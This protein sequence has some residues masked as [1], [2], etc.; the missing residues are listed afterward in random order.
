MPQDMRGQPAAPA[1]QVPCGGLG[2][3]GADA[4][5]GAPRYFTGGRCEDCHFA[6]ERPASCLACFAF[7]IHGSGRVCAAC[8]AFARGKT[9]GPC[10][11]CSR[12]V[13]LKAGHCRLCWKQAAFARSAGRHQDIRRFLDQPILCHQLFFAGMASSSRPA[14]PGPSALHGTWAP[15]FPQA[16][17]A[18]AVPL[19][20][21]EPPPRDFSRF[22]R[23]NADLANPW[24]A[25]ARYQACLHGEAHGWT[26][27]MR[28]CA[29]R[30]L[31]AVLSRHASGERIRRSDLA[32]AERASKIFGP[33][34][35]DILDL[36]GLLDDDRLPALDT[37]ITTTTRGL[38]PGI[39]DDVHYWLTVLRDGT[40]RHRP[41]SPLTVCNH[42]RDAL[43]AL[44]A[45][46]GRYQHLRQVTRSDVTAIADAL[47]G[48]AR[49]RTMSA[50]RSLFRI[51]KGAGRIFRNPAS[52]INGGTPAP[53]LL[54]PLGQ[55]AYDR[56]IQAATQPPARL[57]LALAAMHAA[58]PHAI[59]HLFLTDIDIGDGRITL[60][61]HSRPLDPITRAV[62]LEYLGYRRTRWPGTANPHLLV[63]RSTA[64]G[65]NP[66][67]HAWIK[68]HFTGLTATIEQMRTGRQLEEALSAGPDPLH[69]AAVFGISHQTAIRYAH[70]ARRLL[71][72]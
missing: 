62:V 46:S 58:R 38:T 65:R 22:R 43:P 56:A 8:R 61:G 57:M 69:L 32:T 54:I 53:S 16:P 52:G 34:L 70:A 2:Q 1:R 20:L 37:W 17:A 71:T 27:Q 3:A 60:N 6:G 51:S 42:L 10:A 5:I 35:A 45:W 33:R 19:V 4:I 9:A 47:H 66:S 29:D 21:F 18:S 63:T 13:A 23:E 59:R 40:S 25:Y 31:I 14:A 68:K 49:K 67:S 7:G 48:H 15:D 30:G 72:E 44:T 36:L 41:K 24:L 26:T 50:L 28:R 12:V 39:R 55:A 11:S 64:S